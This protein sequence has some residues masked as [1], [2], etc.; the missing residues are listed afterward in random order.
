MIEVVLSN[1]EQVS[2]VEY[3]RSHVLYKAPEELGECLLGADNGR[4]KEVTG[5]Y[6][7]VSVSARA[8]RRQRNSVNVV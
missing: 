2:L 4:A 3:Q 7:G 1:R 6:S 5:Q 8:V